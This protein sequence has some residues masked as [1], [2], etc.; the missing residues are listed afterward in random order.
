MMNQS[1]KFFFS[2]DDNIDDDNELNTSNKYKADT[3]EGDED[4]VNIELQDN[5]SVPLL[6][7][8]ETRN[9]NKEQNKNHQ[10]QQQNESTI[11]LSIS[12]QKTK[13]ILI[14]SINYYNMYGGLQSLKK[15]E[16]L[17]GTL[18]LYLQ[19]SPFS[20]Q[21]QPSKNTNYPNVLYV[22]PKGH[23]LIIFIS[24]FNI[25]PYQSLLSSSLSPSSSSSYV[26][27]SLTDKNEENSVSDKILT[28]I[29]NSYLHCYDEEAVN[30]GVES[31]INFFYSYGFS[32]KFQTITFP[33]FRGGKPNLNVNYNL[34]EV[35]VTGTTSIFKNNKINK[36]D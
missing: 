6:S 34:N 20:K 14:K 15:H 26:C 33:H 22:I 28:Q 21:H 1:Q 13:D 25:F 4:D 10:Q 3:N 29:D 17:K 36:Q 27:N 2:D 7:D 19:S 23:P 18:T 32:V 11:D 35:K 16:F 5:T 9:T 8:V 31:M 12:I 24:D 30:K